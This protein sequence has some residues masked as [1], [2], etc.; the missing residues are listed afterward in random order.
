M[1]LIFQLLVLLFI[2]K[3][4][5]QE[6]LL[7]SKNDYSLRQ[8]RKLN[9]VTSSQSFVQKLES[10]RKDLESMKNN[11]LSTKSNALQELNSAVTKLAAAGM[12]YHHRI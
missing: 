5:V 4:C 3:I 2:S 1:K 7:K 10:Y 12:Q 9:A 6:I 11:L 8:A